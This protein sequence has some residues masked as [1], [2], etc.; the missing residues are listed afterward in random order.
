MMMRRA[1][2][3]LTVALLSAGCSGKQAAPPADTKSAPQ[4]AAPATAAP[5]TG[6]PK[7]EPGD[8]AV[9][10][11]AYEAVLPEELRGRIDQPF[12]GDLDE[13]VKRRLIRIGVTFNRTFY[14]VDK[15]Q[16]GIAYEYATFSRTR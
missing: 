11:P 13:M 14:F 3:A 10:P 16:R 8:D 9:P 6:A 1:V 5:A 15:A 2:T 7:A 4:A 12:K